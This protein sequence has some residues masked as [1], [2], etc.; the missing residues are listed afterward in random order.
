MAPS[1]KR[2]S[3][4]HTLNATVMHITIFLFINLKV[5]CKSLAS[6]LREW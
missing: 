5:S 1:N 4:A 6:S 3:V 2:L